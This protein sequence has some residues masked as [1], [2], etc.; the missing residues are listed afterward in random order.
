M[1][2]DAKEEVVIQVNGDNVAGASDV[3]F[4]QKG[5]LAV[6]PCKRCIPL[7]RRHGEWSKW[8]GLCHH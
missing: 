1:P 2:T 3:Q 5:S 6:H 4:D 8:V 7:S